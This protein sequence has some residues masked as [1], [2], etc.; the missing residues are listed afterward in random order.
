MVDYTKRFLVAIIMAICVFF[1]IIGG[2]A[3]A[4][5]INIHTATKNW[6]FPANGI[7]SDVYNTRGGTHKGLDIAGKFRSNIY[8]VDDGQVEKSYRSTSYGNVVFIKHPNGLETVYAHLNKRL[9][10]VGQVVKKG[11][12]IGY[13]GNTG[14]STGNH[15]HFEVHNGEW[16]FDKKNAIN[17]FTVFGKGTTGEMVVAKNHDPYELMEV[18]GKSQAQKHIVQ[19]GE[20]LEQIAKEYHTSTKSLKKWNKPNNDVIV[21]GQSLIVFFH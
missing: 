3:Q 14:D 20:T 8:S 4:Q 12:L 7:I 11:Q 13:M 9:V 6:V 18:S 10:R 21:S 16:T 5:E 19:K 1:I 15:L 2:R 17:P